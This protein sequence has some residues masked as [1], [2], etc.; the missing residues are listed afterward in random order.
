MNR[1]LSR[2]IA[3]RLVE[4]AGGSVPSGMSDAEQRERLR[5]APRWWRES[6]DRKR[7]A[8][9][10]PPLFRETRVATAAPPK[11]SKPPR[12]RKVPKAW[13]LVGCVTP[14]TSTPV[15]AATDGL[16]IPE[17]FEPGAFDRSLKALANRETFV[18]LTDG[19]GGKVIA[20]TTDL[21]LKVYADAS[22]GLIAQASIA[23]TAGNRAFIYEVASGTVGYSV[24]YRLLRASIERGRNGRR[25]R[26]VHAATIDHVAVIRGKAGGKPSY[27]SR[28]R[29]VPFGTDDRVARL[30]A[31]LDGLKVICKQ[32]GLTD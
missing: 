9:G 7:E 15:A 3:G 20:S 5:N 29:L 24:G 26:V 31:A 18:D 27:S 23:N 6:F 30:K 1:I 17:R 14:G 16:V 19:H 28:V 22:V 12:K 10:M 32:E 21:T 8:R 2:V 4:Y 13:T 25:V 11:P